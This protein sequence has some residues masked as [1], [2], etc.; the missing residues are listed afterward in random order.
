M[1][2]VCGANTSTSIT[3]YM[4]CTFPLDFLLF[5]EFF[6]ALTPHKSAKVPLWKKL[7]A[8]DSLLLAP[9][10]PCS[11]PLIVHHNR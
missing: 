7:R 11:G 4:T 3:C 2:L 5:S 1:F 6:L 8:P 10:W 9:C